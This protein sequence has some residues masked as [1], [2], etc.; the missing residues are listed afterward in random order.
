MQRKAINISQLQVQPHHLFNSQWLLL[1]AGD[2]QKGHYNTMTIAWGALGTMW[3][4]PFALVAVRHSRFTFEFMQEYNSF[5]LSAFPMKFQD[6]L[7]LLGSRSGRDGDKISDSGLTPEAASSIP[8]P[9]FK[10]A[11]IVLECQKI[12]ANDLNPEHF[13]DPAITSHY[14]RKDYHR[15]YYGEIR[16]TFASEEYTA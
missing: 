3:S 13:L 7:T 6:A 10:E 2:F 1:T 8:S 4:K 15:M 11:V 16:K 12:Y 5:T 9:T 14:P